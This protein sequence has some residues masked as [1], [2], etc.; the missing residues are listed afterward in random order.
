MRMPESDLAILRDEAGKRGIPHSTLAVNILSEVLNGPGV[1][2]CGRSARKKALVRASA[3]EVF[4]PKRRKPKA[5]KPDQ[6]AGY[7]DA[8]K[9]AK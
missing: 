1:A 6:T 7:I 2:T 4:A 9:G 3:R 5:E 8:I